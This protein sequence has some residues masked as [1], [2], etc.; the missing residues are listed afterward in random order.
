M[1]Y[2]FD[3]SEINNWSDTPEAE[4][5]LPKLIGLLLQNTLPDFS[6]RLDMPSGSSVRLPGWDGLLEV[7]RGNTWAPSG[8]SAWE[9]SCAKE[10]TGK[11]NDD[12]EKR[13]TE[14]LGLERTSATFVFVTSRRWTGK[15]QWESEHREEGIWRDVRA[16]DADD[17]VMWL[18][19]APKVSQWFASKIYKLPFD[20]QAINRIEGLQQETKDQVTAGFADMAKMGL[21]LRTLI[22]SIAT[23]AEQP[24]SGTVQDSER[25]S[26]TEKLDSARD[27]IRHGLIATARTQL[28]EIQR[29][30]E[31]LPV[32]LRFRLLT[33]LAVCS[34][35]EA[36]FD[37]ASSLLNEAHR[38]QPE[39]RKGIINAALAAELQQNPKRAA[40]L[41]QR[42]LTLEPRDPSAAAN[43]IS[44]LWGMGESEQ[45]EDF[46]AS[47]EWIA[48]ESASALALA[49]VRV[50]QERYDDAIAVYRS[51]IDADPDDVQ[52]H[53][54][55]SQCL[56]AYAQ[57]NR[58]PVAYSEEELA[59]LREAETEA[60]RAIELL[61]LTQLY[62]RRFDA[63][64]LRAGARAL[65]GKVD[66]AMRDVDAVLDDAPEHSA[67]TLHRGLLLLKMGLAREARS[68]I[69][70]IQDPEVRTDLLLPLADACLETGDA[71]AAVD[72]LRGSF[73]LDPPE[74]EDF[75]RAQSLLR[76]EDAAEADDSVGPMIE[77]AMEQFP[78]N[79]SL[80][81]L[82]A[83]RSDL[84]KDF[85]A[86]ES[87]LIKAI[88]LA[89]EPFRRVLQGQLG[90]LYERVER[91][92]DAGEQFRKACGGDA[93]H[94]DAVLMLMSLSNSGQYRKALDL[95]RE[96]REAVDSI[97]RPVVFL[98]A[99][100]LGYVGDTRAAVSRFRELC[101][102][103]DSDPSD[104]IKLAWAQFRCGERDVAL[105]TILG[106]DVSE[107]GR[108]AQAVMKLAHL[109]RFLGAVDFLS[110]AYLARRHGLND[111]DVH[112]GYFSLFVGL[113]DGW[114]EPA[115]VGPGCAVRLKDAGEE[116]WWYIL[117]DGE[118]PSGRR[119]LSPDEGLAQLLLGRSV[120]DIVDL[121]QSLGSISYEI[122]A[123][124]SKYVRAFQE[125][126]EE[127][128]LRFPQN[129]SLSR[130]EMDSNFTQFFQSIDSRQQYVSN[131]EGL[132]QSRQLPFASFCSLIGSSTFAAWPEYIARPGRQL[133]F[134][135]GSDQETREAGE[136]LRDADAIV[137]DM[138]ALLTVHRLGLAEHLRRRFSRVTIPQLVFDEIQNTV[139]QMRGGPAPSGHA[140][141]DEEGRYTLTEMTEDVWKEMQAFARAVLEL[142]DTFERIPSY[143]LLD[144]DDPQ[145]AFEA[146]TPA[147]A[148]V[149]FAGEDRSKFRLVL[150]S[151]DLP[152]ASVA[153][154][155]EREA[156]NTQALLM[157]LLHT[158]AIT[159]EEYSSKIEELVLSN[160]WFV[161]VSAKDIQRRL[162]ANGFQ[163]TPG[164]RAMLRTLSGPDCSEE[165]A[166]HVGAEVI[167]AVAMK[168]LLPQQL[169]LLLTS[170]LAASCHGRHTNQVLLRFRDEIEDRLIFAPI[171]QAQILEAVDLYTRI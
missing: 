114:E 71:A 89:D 30:S 95:A 134:G 100:I 68:W 91:F 39:N 101:S 44:A 110:D 77:A 29:E 106:I 6:S 12:Y 72:L 168:S 79:P 103:E 160:Y 33:D 154:S 152:L 81:A 65:L 111:P 93:A 8:V 55:L 153:R 47:A 125:T 85:E 87:A 18:E 143:A 78:S 120:G 84:R 132:Y 124:Q 34:L 130:V 7:G 45:L 141:K 35:G 127:F 108:D 165:A 25:K 51:L 162:E 92:A 137:L 155:L 107:L 32:T 76:A 61:Q 146:L 139:N 63:L 118:S 161:R 62:V 140:G 80:F 131:I 14:P 50:R 126:S 31:Q 99:E 148:G 112:L 96:I 60:D 147:G 150:I 20:H 69:E 166:V 70:G 133:H 145:A 9:F 117:E 164:I 57:V 10:V 116:H 23:Q 40:E 122:T 49:G 52:V 113:E 27:L 129:M 128:S 16:F 26:W 24:D 138:V 54:G 157:E 86:T 82:A 105:E 53:L 56:L 36:Q 97:P 2:S 42:A 102:Q 17:L 13:T 109:K 38:I 19:Q 28:E 163:T 66:E 121:R 11:A 1:T 123:L 90:R 48:E 75:G 43:L 169:N 41:A 83:V 67:A 159:A 151:D 119:E 4:H 104:Q 142:A 158:S 115:V 156:V 46:V 98:E 167:A 88:D 74:R 135:T 73:K 3:A 64:V 149:V 15:R 171:Q 21:E 37:E 5:T 94:P 136:L 22:T 59:R 144:V 58:L 170:V